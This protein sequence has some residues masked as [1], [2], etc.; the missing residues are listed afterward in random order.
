MAKKNIHLVPCLRGIKKDLKSTPLIVK[1][2]G[3]IPN[4]TEAVEG[5]GFIGANQTEGFAN[6]DF[7]AETS[8]GSSDIEKLLG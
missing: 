6:L 8:C 1:M 5:C 3:A 4:S 7:I 2:G